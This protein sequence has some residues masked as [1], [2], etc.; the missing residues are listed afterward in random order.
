VRSER[1][2]LLLNDRSD[3]A[4]LIETV[5]DT[6]CSSCSRGRVGA[7]PTLGRLPSIALPARPSSRDCRASAFEGAGHPRRGSLLR[8]TRCLPPGPVVSDQCLPPGPPRRIGPLGRSSCGKRSSRTACAPAG[9]F[10]RPSTV[11]EQRAQPEAIL[12]VAPD[13]QIFTP[14]ADELRGQKSLPLQQPV[15]AVLRTTSDVYRSRQ[16]HRPTIHRPDH[17]PAA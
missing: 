10:A 12:S 8:S 2:A 5:S 15:W 11:F 1:N 6:A 9:E 14:R 3:L 16:A 17:T 13:S 7:R 4:H